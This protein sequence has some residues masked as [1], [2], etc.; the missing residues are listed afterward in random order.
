MPE[1]NEVNLLLIIEFVLVPECNPLKVNLEVQKKLW[2]VYNSLG[3]LIF[4]SVGAENWCL[5]H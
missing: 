3:N 5:L 1:I 4:G 2:S